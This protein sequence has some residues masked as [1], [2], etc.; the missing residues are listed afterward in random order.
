MGKIVDVMYFF[1]FFFFIKEDSNIISQEPGGL[2]QPKP[3][4]KLNDDSV[5][6]SSFFFFFAI[7]FLTFVLSNLAFR[8]DNN[9][10]GLRA[11]W[12]MIVQGDFIFLK[13]SM[14]FLLDFWM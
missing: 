14:L 7:T 3:C 4:W 10:V 11:A 12:A 13:Q 2:K 1:F 6:C 5:T 9:W 8:F